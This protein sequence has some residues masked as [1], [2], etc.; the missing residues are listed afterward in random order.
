MPAETIAFFKKA[1][2]QQL[3]GRTVS[4]V[5]AVE[6]VR[7]ILAS[8]IVDG[9]AV[10]PAEMPTSWLGT[11]TTWL[12]APTVYDVKIQKNDFVVQQNITE[13]KEPVNFQVDTIYNDQYYIDSY[14]SDK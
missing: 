12:N 3:T 13:P 9:D 7:D 4:T 14:Y 5:L 6:S 2:I 1:T 11:T 8:G 10:V